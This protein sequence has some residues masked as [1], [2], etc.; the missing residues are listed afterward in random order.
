GV[1]SVTNSLTGAKAGDQVG[2]PPPIELTNGNYLVRS[3]NW[4]SGVITD[5][6]AV[7]WAS[8]ISATTGLVSVTNS[9]VGATPFDGVGTFVTALKNSNYVQ[10]TPSWNGQRGAATWGNGTT[11]TTGV[12]T[13][14]NSLVGSQAGNQ[15]GSVGVIALANGNYVVTSP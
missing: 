4:D 15:V 5:A 13:A 3:S 8:G 1:I 10:A 7:T 14:T 6:G 11:G 12:V 2:V 9:L